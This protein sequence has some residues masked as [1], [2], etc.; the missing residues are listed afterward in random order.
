MKVAGIADRIRTQ[1]SANLVSFVGTALDLASAK[2]GAIQFPAVFVVE[3]GDDAG[4]NERASGRVIQRVESQ[5]GVV[6]AMQDI[7]RLRGER[8]QDALEDL[9]AAIRAALLA[10]EP[11]AGAEPMIFAQGRLLEWNEFSLWW[12]DAYLTATYITG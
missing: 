5:I 10:W 6:I 12:Q 3:L 1:V 7:G 11:E 9:R 4:D 8:G 2:E